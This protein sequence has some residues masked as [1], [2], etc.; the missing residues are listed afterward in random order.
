M[1]NQPTET[2]GTSG[3]VCARDVGAAPAGEYSPP[4]L[5]KYGTISDV[6]GTFGDAGALDGGAG[7]AS[8]SGGTPPAIPL[9]PFGPS[10][11]PY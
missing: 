4:V 2:T 1:E 11:R 8:K 6:T 3:G 5:A 10:S 9:P 7:G